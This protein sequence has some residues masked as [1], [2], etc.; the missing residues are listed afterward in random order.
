MSKIAFP[1][2]PQHDAEFT[3]PKGHE[4]E[5]KVV[6]IR[7]S[8]SKNGVQPDQVDFLFQV[9]PGQK[10]DRA[11]NPT[12]GIMAGN[13][14]VSG[15]PVWH[16]GSLNGGAAAITMKTMTVSGYSPEAV[17][18]AYANDPEAVGILQ[19][20]A[21]DMAG[22]QTEEMPV[23]YTSILAEHILKEQVNALTILALIREDVEALGLGTKTV[24]LTVMEDTYKDVTRRRCN[25]VNA[26]P[27]APVAS[28]VRKLLNSGLSAALSAKQAAP[29][30][31][32]PVAG[33][34]APPA[35]NNIHDV[36]F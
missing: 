9:N 27:V 4:V 33:K 18:A 3:T 19:Q 16:T 21:S 24:K 8:Q 14:D 29:T 22:K 6:G 23:S 20:V 28:D 15:W 5:A 1:E 25:Y 13:G 34:S 30:S 12:A 17:K 11:A 35:G 2:R 32:P 26:L 10:A 7:L 31:K 36:D